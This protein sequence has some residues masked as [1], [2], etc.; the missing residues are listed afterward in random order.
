MV[1]A[2]AP[3]SDLDGWEKLGNPGWGSHE[4]IPLSAKAE[5]FQGELKSKSGHHGDSGPIKISRGGPEETFTIGTQFLE[6]AAAYD[7]E[8]GFIE[9]TE[10][11]TTC[12]AYGPFHRYVDAET[13]RRSDTAHHYVYTQEANKNLHIL[14]KHRVSR[15]IIENNR[16][17]GVEYTPEETGTSCGLQN[18]LKAFAS[19]LVVV[20]A[21]SFG[22]PTILQRSGIAS[23]VLLELNQ[24]E[25][26]VDLPGVGENYN[27]HN[28]VFPP[29]L[30]SEDLVSLNKVF[31]ATEVTI[32]PY[33]DQWKNDGQGLLVTNGLNSGIKL[34]PNEK[35]LTVL[36]DS[37]AHLWESKFA[38]S[39]DKPVL[40]IANIAGFVRGEEGGKN[41]FQMGYFV[42]YPLAIGHVR[43][44][45]GIDPFARLDFN[46]R[47]LEHEAD[48][49]VLRWGYK[50]TR[51]L[52]RRMK[53][54]RG[55]FVSLHP[56][57]PEGSA[58]TTREASGPVA[59]SDP[60]ILYTSEDDKAIDDYHRAYVSTAWHA[61]G[62]CAMK[63]REQGG[64][65]DPRLNVYG[66]KNLK[67][68]DLS[69]AP[70]NVGAN[71]YNTAIIIGEK[72]ALI[73]AEEL[74]STKYGE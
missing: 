9:D 51:E 18:C 25:Q 46:P 5:T 14:V 58:A 47:Y 66:V 34:R 3:A 64:V 24:V 40:C 2:R 33:L 54:F 56:S 67:V 19:R 41:C 28:V 29:Y 74:Q 1:Y 23:K 45:S 57:F 12:D 48:L 22:S 65:V 36:G 42:E 72:A 37:F 73:I 69:I 17:V 15:V 63:P 59:I 10:D 30:T 71:T 35:D 13:G 6:T 16:A 38:N 21:G 52:A 49:A 32:Q 53:C 8:R 60:D 39:P 68:A 11:F 26:I 55:E 7:L 61:L 70:L 4:L 43:I 31:C 27:D 62:T 44:T 50:R 20:S